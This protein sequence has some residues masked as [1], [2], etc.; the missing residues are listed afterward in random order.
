[1]YKLLTQRDKTYSIVEEKPLTREKQLI[2]ISQD[3]DTTNT[4]VRHL[5]NGG[6]FNGWT[7]TFFNLNHIG[8]N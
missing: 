6:G 7:P 5:K 4:L 8:E 3:Y 2:Y 1:M